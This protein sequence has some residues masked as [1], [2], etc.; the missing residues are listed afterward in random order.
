[1]RSTNLTLLFHDGQPLDERCLAQSDS[2]QGQNATT[3]PFGKASAD[4]A[5]QLR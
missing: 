3:R 4:C 2:R 1:L 5:E